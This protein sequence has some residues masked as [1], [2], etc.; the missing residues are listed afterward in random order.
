LIDLADEVAYNAADLDDA[1]EAG[2][3]TPERI[4]DAVPAYA[5]LLD[6]V[7]TQFPGATERERFGESIRLLI[8][9][10]VSGFIEGTV[11][12]VR[13]AAVA[14]FESVRLFPARLARFT[15]QVR[16]TSSRFKQFL[17]ANVY[18]SDE[19]E[20]ER[21]ASIAK[22]ERLF[23]FLLD[24]PEKMPASEEPVERAVCNFIAGMTDRYFL[25]FYDTMFSQR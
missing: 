1:F 6:T 25:R 10:Q 20:Q 18:T 16:E 13:S 4:A 7:E 21:R 11:E 5:D 12:A 8:D 15:P 23:E 24:H 17:L 19:L 9:D 3:L 2:L 14:D 22:L